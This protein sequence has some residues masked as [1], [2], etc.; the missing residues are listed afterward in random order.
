MEKMV[1]I[2]GPH[3][4]QWINTEVKYGLY[5][6]LPIHRKMFANGAVGS[7]PHA[8]DLSKTAAYTRQEFA[9]NKG[10]VEAWVH[11]STASP[12]KQLLRGYHRSV[13]L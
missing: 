1:I 5:L 7:G 11:A 2:G 10:V 3:D 4:G 9:D 6:H 12:M 8:W 13:T